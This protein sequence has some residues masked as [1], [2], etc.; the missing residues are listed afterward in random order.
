MDIIIKNKLVGRT[1][2]MILAMIPDLLKG[3]R[4][5]I[6][7]CKE[8][9]RITELLR[10]N[11]VIIESEPMYTTLRTELTFRSYNLSEEISGLKN[12][13]KVISGFVFWKVNNAYK[14]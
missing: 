14:K 6:M 5:S 12:G 4:V 1:N 8:T 9:T 13:E 2:E 7:G 10:Q 3:V 11:G